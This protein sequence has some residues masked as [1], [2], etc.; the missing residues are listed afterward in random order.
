MAGFP[1]DILNLNE[2]MPS[3]YGFIAWTFDPVNASGA[4]ELSSPGTL[5]L[6]S[7]VLRSSATVSN[8]V[9]FVDAAGASLT[10]NECFMGIYDYESW[11]LLAQT[12]DQSSAWTST[13][14]KTMPLSA[15]V[16]LAK[17][18]YWIAMLANGTT[19]PQWARNP[20]N[21]GTLLS[22]YF[23]GAS[24]GTGL[25]ALPSSLNTIG[26]TGQPYVMLAA[27]T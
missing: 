18:V 22:G 20:N 17:G 23:R 7:V 14:S 6:A 10:A 13:G 12:P 26:I 24:S 5:A 16:V 4:G 27:L 9:A 2:F 21:T 19:A 3:D 1:Q 11:D 8:I 25:T 15:P